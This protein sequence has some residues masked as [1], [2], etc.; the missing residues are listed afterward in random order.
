LL[1][2]NHGVSSTFS[3]LSCV[4][5]KLVDVLAKPT[6]APERRCWAVACILRIAVVDAADLID[7]AIL[8]VAETTGD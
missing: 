3:I 2:I 8:G 6:A 7:G 4:V 1:L 5:G